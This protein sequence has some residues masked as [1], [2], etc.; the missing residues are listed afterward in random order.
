MRA[1]SIVVTCVG[2]VLAACASDDAA[3]STPES[4]PAAS[5]S[6]GDVPSEQAAALADGTVTAT[7]YRAAFD[8]FQQCVTD[9][10]GSITLTDTD[11]VTGELT[12]TSSGDLLAP[13]Q[14]GGST[15]NE[16][17][18]R[19]FAQVEVTFSLTDPGV[20]DNLSSEQMQ[21]F[22]QTIRPCLEYAGVDIPDDLAYGTADWLRMLDENTRA[23]NAGECPPELVYSTT[24]GG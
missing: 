10:G 9:G 5:S 15:E 22:D 19:F 16:C 3:G 17:Y 6:V 23:L 1:I 11:A 18:Q 24:I 7:E 8:G 12:Y 20:Q 2:V 4:R 13:G 14:M 21:I